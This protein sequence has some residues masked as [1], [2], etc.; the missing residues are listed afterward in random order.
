V[1]FR[2]HS[3]RG[4][5]EKRKKE[6]NVSGP[7]DHE[8][9]RKEISA[10]IIIIPP[11]FFWDIIGRSGK[12]ETGLGWGSGHILLPAYLSGK[13]YTHGRNAFGAGEVLEREWGLMFEERKGREK[14]EDEKLEP[15]KPQNQNNKEVSFL[16]DLDVFPF[17][18]PH[19][20]V[21]RESY[22]CCC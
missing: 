22:C 10:T 7:D 6:R 13:A 14:E 18:V 12:R 2:R 3:L 20:K 21:N 4:E 17:E 1:S 15:G 16:P 19:A 8:T 11:H 5:G 9:T